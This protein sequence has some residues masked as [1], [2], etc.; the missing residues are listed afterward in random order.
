MSATIDNAPADVILNEIATGLVD[1]LNAVSRLSKKLALFMKAPPPPAPARR[2]IAAPVAR[3][4]LQPEYMP[5]LTQE[6]RKATRRKGAA[7]K[8]IAAIMARQGVLASE[9]STIAGYACGP[10]VLD[11]L[12]QSRGFT[13]REV[14]TGAN[15]RFIGKML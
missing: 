10:A 15:R 9:L 11:R 14:G 1:A 5:P 7:N 12:A 4:T 13:W 6:R 2:A 8:I 3:I